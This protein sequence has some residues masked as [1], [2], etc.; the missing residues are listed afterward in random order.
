[1]SSYIVNIFQTLNLYFPC[2]ILPSLFASYGLRGFNP[3]CLYKTTDDYIYIPDDKKYHR[4]GK[5]SPADFF[6]QAITDNNSHEE[7]QCN[8]I[9]NASYLVDLNCWIFMRH[10]SPRIER[11]QDKNNEREYEFHIVFIVLYGPWL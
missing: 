6:I 10:I 8:K 11:C 4:K 2:E 3:P 7:D 9:E 5:V 1:M